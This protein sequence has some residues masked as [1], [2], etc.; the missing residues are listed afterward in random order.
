[1]SQL[2]ARLDDVLTKMKAFKDQMKHVTQEIE[3]SKI[4]LNAVAKKSG[5]ET[6]EDEEKL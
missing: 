4:L 2:G 1:M 3:S 6:F 5:I